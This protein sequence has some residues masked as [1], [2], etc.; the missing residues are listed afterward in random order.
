MGKFSISLRLKVV[1]WL[2][3]VVMAAAA[4]VMFA[5]WGH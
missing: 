4:V 2:A 5:T 3:T 1:G